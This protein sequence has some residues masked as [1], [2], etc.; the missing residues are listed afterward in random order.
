MKTRVALMM[1][2]MFLAVAAEANVWNKNNNYFT[3]TGVLTV[4][5]SQ[6]GSGTVF[7]FR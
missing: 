1:L 5:Q 3:D 6:P 2:G 4:L 7:R